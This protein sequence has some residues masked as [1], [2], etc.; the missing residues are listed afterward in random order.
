[1]NERLKNEIRKYHS[2]HDYMA[3]Y[4][5]DVA[6]YFYNLALDDIKKEVENRINDCE[7]FAKRAMTADDNMIS[8]T[9]TYTGES[10][11]NLLQFINGQNS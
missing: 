8:S 4:I 1:M 2:E 5:E 7:E 10:Y 11:K 3:M 9:W 6:N